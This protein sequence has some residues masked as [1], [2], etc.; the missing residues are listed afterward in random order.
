MPN[1]K[2]KSPEVII[3][4]RDVRKSFGN[5]EVL[6]G[7]SLDVIQAKTMVIVGPSGSGKSTLIRCFNILETINAGEILFEG[8]AISGDDKN[9]WK[10]RLEIGMVF[11][12]FELFPASPHRR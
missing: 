8:K 2:N 1:E 11:Q 12:N 9:A 7:I 4:V 5:L 10:T 3:K 6:K